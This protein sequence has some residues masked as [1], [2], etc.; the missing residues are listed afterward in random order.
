MC[1]LLELDDFIKCFPLLKS[2]DK[3][4]TQDQIWKQI[5][6]RTCTGNFIHPYDINRYLYYF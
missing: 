4:R 2:R 5:C 1:Q 6:E 3:L